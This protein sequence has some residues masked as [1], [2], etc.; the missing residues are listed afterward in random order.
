MPRAILSTF[1]IFL[2]VIAI[3]LSQTP[4]AKPLQREPLEKYDNPPPLSPAVDTSPGLISQFGPYTSYQA[5]VVNGNII[6]RA[7][8]ND[9]SICVDLIHGDKMSISWRHIISVSQKF[10]HR[11]FL[12]RANGGSPWV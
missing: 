3:A 7:A 8:A 10:R 9:P 1:L 11:C 2:N 5:N 12:Y 6:A 4:T